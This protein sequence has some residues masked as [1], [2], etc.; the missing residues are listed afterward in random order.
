MIKPNSSELNKSL[1]PISKFCNWW[2]NRLFIAKIIAIIS[3]L[4]LT[5]VAF[6]LT[7]VPLRDIW[8]NGKI[9]VGKFKA[10]P[11]EYKGLP[12]TI[13]PESWREII[14]KYDL[15]K[16]IL[17]YRDTQNYLEE[18]D[19][20]E[21]AIMSHGLDSPESQEILSVLRERSINMINEDPFKLANK[22]G[23]LERIKNRM[24]EHMDQYINNPQESSKLAF[25]AFWTVKHLQDRTKE[26]ILF[27]NEKIKPLINTNYY[28]PID[29]TGNYVDYFGLIDF[30]FIVIIFG[31]FI[32][33]CYAISSRYHGVNFRDAILW[34]WYDLIFFLP[35]WRWLRIIPVTIRLDEAKSLDSKGVKKQL[36]QGFVASIAGDVTE[37]VVLRVI[38]QIQN[39]I[40]E[41]QIEKLLTPSADS[42]EYID[43][44]DVNEIAEISKLLINL[45][46]YQVLPEI[47]PEVESLLAYTIEKGIT[48]A[49]AYQNVSR[50]P[51]FDQFPKNIS[52][53][54]S[55]QVYQVLSDSIDKVLQDDPVFDQYLTEIINK[56]S[57]TFNLR[58]GAR[59]DVNQIEKL[60]VALLEEVKVNYV[61]NLSDE[62]IENLLDET[63]A[64]KESKEL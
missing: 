38:N 32:I 22:S 12:L 31:D 64:L 49:P 42:R 55:T 6:D 18:V 52:T 19:N 11:Y 28:R 2:F 41:G 40:K 58:V 24:R 45:V 37:V 10:G 46:A 47:R 13:V 7:Y 23:T 53:R 44:N 62:D 16:G 36:S 20:L 33:R 51:G 5:V 43:L 39:V 21:K 27:F 30:P 17:P 26:E 8:L 35:T 3:V 15:V 61:Q 34:R 14:T 54:I 57:Q 9:T 63:R 56:C 1:N 50:L 59:Q 4:N 48:E 29:E 25:S 60:L